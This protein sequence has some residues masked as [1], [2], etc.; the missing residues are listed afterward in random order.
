EDA[1]RGDVAVL[2]NDRDAD[3]VVAAFL[4]LAHLRV[5]FR[6][7]ETGVRIERAEHPAHGAVDEIVGI[8]LVD[9]VRFDRAERRREGSVVLRHLVVGC[10]RAPSE[11]AADQRRHE[12]REHDSGQRTV[13]SHDWHR[14]RQVPYGQRLLDAFGARIPCIIDVRPRD[15]V[16][17]REGGGLYVWFHRDARADHHFCDRSHYFWAA[18]AA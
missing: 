2:R 4:P 17:D 6:A 14:S 9:V 13:A 15:T 1:H 11:E 3:A 5:L 18:K 7:E 16:L 12:N 10:E 8:D